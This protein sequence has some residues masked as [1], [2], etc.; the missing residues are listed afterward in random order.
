MKPNKLLPKEFIFKGDHVF[1]KKEGN[2][3]ILIPEKK[4]WDILIRSLEK[5]SDDFMSERT[6]PETQKREKLFGEVHA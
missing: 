2:R 1:I 5:F 3:E 4:T 6:Q